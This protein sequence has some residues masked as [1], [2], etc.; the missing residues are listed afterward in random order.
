MSKMFYSEQFSLVYFKFKWFKVLLGITNNS[1]KYQ[2]FIDT[3][4]DD[5]TVLF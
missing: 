1:I 2:L 5:K 4:I 3:Q